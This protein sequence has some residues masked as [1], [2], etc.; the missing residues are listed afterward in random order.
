[1]EAEVTKI[2]FS[3]MD[4]ALCGIISDFVFIEMKKAFGT[5]RLTRTQFGSLLDIGLREKVHKLVIDYYDFL[6][7][8]E[9]DINEDE[10]YHYC[11]TD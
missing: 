6:G 11:V 7:E 2:E 3:G 8:I 4:N 1:M 5:S 9:V 10:L